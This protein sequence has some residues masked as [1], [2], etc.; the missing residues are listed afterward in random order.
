MFKLL[1]ISFH[2]VFERKIENEKEFL[3]IELLTLNSFIEISRI[4]IRTGN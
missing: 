4:D 1:W 2:Q 3:S